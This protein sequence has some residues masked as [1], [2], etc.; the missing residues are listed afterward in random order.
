MIFKDRIIDIINTLED[1]KAILLPC[2]HRWNMAISLSNTQKFKDLSDL[3]FIN[4][5]ATLLFE[6]LDHLKSYLPSL[7][8]RVE[9]LLVYY[10]R[11]FLMQV[12][13]DYIFNAEHID[14]KCF[15]TIAINDYLK[16]IVSLLGQ[17]LILFSLKDEF[18][19]IKLPEELP[20][21]V[22][23]QVDYLCLETSYINPDEDYVVF[24]SDDSGFLQEV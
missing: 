10:N 4:K 23:N 3:I 21:N 11:P 1:G 18:N 17:P 6:N 2:E 5:T 14:D 19:R 24:E 22:L 12:E 16:T 8:P 20:N 7:H 9:T 13:S 15:L